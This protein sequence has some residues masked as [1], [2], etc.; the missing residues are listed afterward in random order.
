[1]ERY[2]AH[3]LRDLVYKSRFE[4]IYK[5]ILDSAKN[6]HMN[7]EIWWLA[8]DDIEQLKTQ[9]QWYFLDVTITDYKSYSVIS[10][11]AS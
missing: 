1:M 8:N 9:I 10:W 5:K 3:T 11:K 7:V 6:G 2:T 4:Q